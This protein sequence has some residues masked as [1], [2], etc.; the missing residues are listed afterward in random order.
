M[1]G[2]DG[3]VDSKES[4]GCL[5]QGDDVDEVF[6][7]EPATLHEL[8]LDCCNHGDTSTDGE[9]A[10]FCKHKKYLPETYHRCFLRFYGFGCKGTTSIENKKIRVSFLL[11]VDG[12]I[13]VSGNQ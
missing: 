3:Y 2:E 4:G 7:V 5:C 1:A 11:F 8:A 6:V 9:G 13:G 12:E 10:N